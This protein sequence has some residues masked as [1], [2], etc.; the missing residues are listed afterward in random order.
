MLKNYELYETCL[1][2][3]VGLYVCV[4]ELMVTFAHVQS[5]LIDD[6][7]VYMYTYVHTYVFIAHKHMYSHIF[8]YR[9]TFPHICRILDMKYL[10]FWF[11]SSPFC[12]TWVDYS[13]PW[14]GRLRL[15]GETK[16]Q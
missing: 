12:W 11:A 2:L 3:N 13:C 5:V 10:S 1:S 8:T 16:C 7:N 15:A 6:L 14:S 9:Y 4:L